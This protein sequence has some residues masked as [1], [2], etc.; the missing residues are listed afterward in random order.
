MYRKEIINFIET[1]VDGKTLFTMEE[2]GLIIKWGREK[3]GEARKNG[4]WDAPKIPAVTGEQ[5]VFFGAAK[6]VRARLCKFSGNVII[7]KE[8]LHAGI[9]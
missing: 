6:R 1:N 8:N 4:Q 3:V 5:I 9:F 2:Q 7:S